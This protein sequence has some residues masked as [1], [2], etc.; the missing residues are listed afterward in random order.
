M[1]WAAEAGENKLVPIRVVLV[2]RAMGKGR[3]KTRAKKEDVGDK[4]D[5]GSDNVQDEVKNKEDEGITAEYIGNRI[6][7]YV[8]GGNPV[9][10]RWINTYL[11][12]HR[13]GLMCLGLALGSIFSEWLSTV[14]AP[15]QR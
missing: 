14:I 10:I 1:D 15:V 7:F 2:F 9:L 8:A 13:F 3:P 5:K 12:D 6:I 4:G 11:M